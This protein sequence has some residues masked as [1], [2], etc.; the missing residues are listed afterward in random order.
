M[1]HHPLHINDVYAA[2][3]QQGR[4]VVAGP[5]VLV[6]GA[7]Y[8]DEATVREFGGNKFP[9]LVRAG[10]AVTVRVAPAAQRYAG[11]FYG[12]HPD[13]EAR[14]TDAAHTMTFVACPPGKHQSTAPEPVTFWSGFVIATRPGCVALDVFADGERTPRRVHSERGRRCA[15]PPGTPPLRSCG[16]RAEGGRP[17]VVVARPGDVVIGPV[18][19]SGLRRVFSARGFEHDRAGSVYLVKAG[20]MVRA[21]VRATLIVGAGS[22]ERAALTF[23]TRRLRSL[24]DGHPA[25]TFEACDAGEPAFSYDGEVGIVTGFAGGFILRRA[26][27]VAL[28]VRAAGRRSVRANVPFGVGRCPA[29]R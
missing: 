5:L 23:A 6:G 1:N 11:L 26:G 24:S 10:H 3:S 25:V 13:G 12:P 8:T 21:G 15:T 17:P 27:C 4:N 16:S 2:D 20:A 19:L 18:A 29:A 22:R 14:L 28:E 9:L 7:T